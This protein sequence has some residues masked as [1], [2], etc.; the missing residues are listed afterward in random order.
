MTEALRPPG[1]HCYSSPPSAYGRVMAYLQPYEPYFTPVIL[2]EWPGR[3]RDFG[4]A[5]S[6]ML[7]FLLKMRSAVCLHR[8]AGIARSLRTSSLET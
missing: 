4:Q 7:G 8:V 3:P 1:H 5:G 2:L 6:L